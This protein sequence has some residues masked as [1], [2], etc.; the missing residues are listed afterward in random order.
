GSALVSRTHCAFGLHL[1]I[2]PLALPSIGG[3]LSVPSGL[4][5]LL[6]AICPYSVMAYSVAQRFHAIDSLTTAAVSD[7]LLR[8]EPSHSISPHGGCAWLPSLLF[9]SPFFCPP[10]SSL[11]PVPSCTHC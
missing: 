4:G 8:Q 11:S 1:R 2:F 3:F 7:S 5:L 10:S 9:G 6:A